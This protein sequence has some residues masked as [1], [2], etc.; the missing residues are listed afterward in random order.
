MFELADSL[1]LGHK[2]SQM[3]RGYLIVTISVMAKRLQ[4]KPPN[5]APFYQDRLAFYL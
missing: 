3:S 1:A 4:L 5:L 2:A